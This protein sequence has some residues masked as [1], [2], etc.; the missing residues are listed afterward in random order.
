MAE[1]APKSPNEVKVK[2][3]DDVVLHVVAVNDGEDPPQR[4]LNTFCKGALQ[5]H[6]GYHIPVDSEDD[7]IHGINSSESLPTF[8]C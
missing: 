2:H 3:G 6:W 8:H 7:F 4:I 5:F 1:F